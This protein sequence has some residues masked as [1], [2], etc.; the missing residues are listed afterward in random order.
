MS[1]QLIL[2]LKNGH[3]VNLNHTDSILNQ[4]KKDYNS[5]NIDPD[6]NDLNQPIPANSTNILSIHDSDIICATKTILGLPVHS[7]VQAS[8]IFTYG[9]ASDSLSPPHDKSTESVT[10]K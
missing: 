5:I 9:S 8:T 10:P 7:P 6:H 4:N 3:N 1:P 2:K